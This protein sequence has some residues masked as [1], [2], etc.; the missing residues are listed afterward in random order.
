[1]MLITE[2][3]LTLN[4]KFKSSVEG[5]VNMVGYVHLWSIQPHQ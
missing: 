4:M 2:I 5:A 3:S 1:M